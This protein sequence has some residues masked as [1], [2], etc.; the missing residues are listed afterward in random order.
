[1]SLVI[2]DRHGERKTHLDLLPVGITAYSQSSAIRS[3]TC[4]TS[5]TGIASFLEWAG[6]RHLRKDGVQS[7][8]FGENRWSRHVD[9]LLMDAR[10]SLLA[11]G[12]HLRGFKIHMNPHSIPV[13]ELI[14]PYNCSM[15]DP[16]PIQRIAS[17]L[18]GRF[19][20]PRHW[21]AAVA[22]DKETR[23]DIMDV[24]LTIQCAFNA[25]HPTADPL[26]IVLDLETKDVLPIGEEESYP[27]SVHIQSGLEIKAPVGKLES[28]FSIRR[29]FGDGLFHTLL[30][31]CSDKEKLKISINMER[32]MFESQNAF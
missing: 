10:H 2:V 1:M 9:N 19:A 30:G 16:L 31:A 3:L 15:V 6:E 5:M 32:L 13:L 28:N 25:A 24:G 18:P 20:I 26:Q 12:T 8:Y 4:L 27:L 29:P 14:L 23:L 21:T 22:I 7:F 11:E 17:P